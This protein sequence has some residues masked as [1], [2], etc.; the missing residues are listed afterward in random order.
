MNSLPEPLSKEDLKEAVLSPLQ[1]RTPYAD[2]L[3][4]EKSSIMLSAD[5]GTGKSILALQATC[6][7]A[8]GL[9]LFGSLL[10]PNP[11]K[12]YYIQKE[13]PQLEVLERLKILN[14]SIKIN[15]DNLIVDS[16]LQILNLSDLKYCDLIASRIAK[17]EPKLIVIDPI[18]AGLG[19]LSKDEI[20]NNFCTMLTFIQSRIGNTYWL[21]HHTTKQQYTQTGEKIDKEKPFYGSQWLD[22]FVTGHYHITGNDNG[23]NWRKTKDNYGLLLSRFSLEYEP[24]TNLSYLKLDN[25][26]AKDKIINYINSIKSHKK[27]FKFSELAQVTG[28]AIRTLRH[29]LTDPIFKTLL[30]SSKAIGEATLYEIIC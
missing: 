13:R 7:L 3:L 21:N 24:D 26:L 17:H 1:K 18:G 23:T 22:A 14:E 2:G 28:C 8:S 12:V 27:S 10:V 30:K 9:P 11:I 4:F 15:W 5:P 25:M 6:Q 16:L 20:A 19:G 29:T